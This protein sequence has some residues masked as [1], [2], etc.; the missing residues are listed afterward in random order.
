MSSPER[1]RIFP[2][3]R[4]LTE[5]IDELEFKVKELRA[6]R[7]FSTYPQLGDGERTGRREVDYRELRCEHCRRRLVSVQ[8]QQKGVCALCDRFG[9][10]KPPVVL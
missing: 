8:S 7:N 10:G 6:A 2:S 5:Q 9:P 3:R 1:G 4:Q